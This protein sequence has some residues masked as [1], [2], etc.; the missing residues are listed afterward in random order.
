MGGGVGDGP[1]E[2]GVFVGGL[3]ASTVDI[4]SKLKVNSNKRI[5]TR[6]IV[7]RANLGIVCSSGILLN[8]EH[9]FKI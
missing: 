5:P 9:Q 6:L 7:R 3:A 8:T 4:L 2:V 1:A